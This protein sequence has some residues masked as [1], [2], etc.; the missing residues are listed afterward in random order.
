MRPGIRLDPETE[1][2]IRDLRAE[3][4]ALA[5][6]VQALEARTSLLEESDFELVPPAVSPSSLPAGGPALFS[7]SLC[8]SWSRGFAPSSLTGQFP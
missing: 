5:L 3:V 2:L 8:A 6:R 1:Q 4:R 7:F